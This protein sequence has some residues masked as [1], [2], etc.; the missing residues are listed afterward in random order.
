MPSTFWLN[1][2]AAG[3][4]SDCFLRQVEASDKVIDG[5]IGRGYLQP[6]RRRRRLDEAK[7]IETIL[8]DFF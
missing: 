2:S 5:L 4:G 6:D 7:A 1:R 8:A 3:A